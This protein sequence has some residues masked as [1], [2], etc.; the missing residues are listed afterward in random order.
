MNLTEPCSDQPTVGPVLV[1][2]MMRSGTT[3]VGRMLCAGGRL[4]YVSEPL[5]PYH[6]GIFRLPVA[7]DYTYISHENEQGFLRPFQDAVALKSRPFKELLAVRGPADV[8]RVGLTAIE[9]LR[10]RMGRRAVLLKDP[11]ALFS[12][13]WFADLLGCRVVICV[14]H[15]AAV[16][17]SHVRLGWRAPLG[18][19]RAQPALVR[20]LL[21]P[22]E[23]ELA[24]AEQDSAIGDD[25]LR[26]NALLWKIIYGTVATYA[27]SR[28]DFTIVR[29]EDL[30]SRPL[31]AYD[32]L[33]SQLGLRFDDRAAGQIESATSQK[34]PAELRV[35][36]PHRIRLDSRSNLGNWHKRL[37]PHDVELIR[38]IV[39]P[40]AARW[41]DDSDWR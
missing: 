9:L 40:V 37:A 14:R 2:G 24:D 4:S 29:H 26:G 35:Q 10:G 21:S 36:D 5:N 8:R 15:P 6:P 30:S 7:H 12:A 11:H 38:E 32:H 39:E 25:P 33:Y 31:E 28:P 3:W 17:S 1:T 19:L 13:P 22:Y 18:H 27:E 16:V 23:Q 34:N 20:D 41:Y